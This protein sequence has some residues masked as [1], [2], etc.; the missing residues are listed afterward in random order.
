VTDKRRVRHTIQTLQRVKTWQLVLL[1]I[2]AGF[3]TATFLRLNNIGMV[4]RRSAVITADNTGDPKQI[5]DRLSELQRY[6]S[7]HMN[8]D[9]GQGVYLEASYKRDYEK[10][11]QAAANSDNGNGNIYKKAQEVCA[12]R[13]TRYSTAYLECTLTE[14]QKYPAGSNLATQVTL[15]GNL[16]VHDFVSPVWSPDFAGFSLLVT[17]FLALLI[18]VRLIGLLVLRI[19]LRW[20]YKSI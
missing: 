18:V 14:L 5:N 16:Y 13:Y 3:I 6:V 1:L 17:A 9:L 2:L 19:L 20:Q 11:E 8:T 10:A 7:E 15:N 12:P 4:Q